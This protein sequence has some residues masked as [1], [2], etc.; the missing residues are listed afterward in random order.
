MIIIFH[1]WNVF[2]FL[3]EI[4]S[5]TFLGLTSRERKKAETGEGTIVYS[6][7]NVSDNNML[8]DVSQY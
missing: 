3:G 4:T 5:C 2:W 8:A 7:H 6:S 1:L